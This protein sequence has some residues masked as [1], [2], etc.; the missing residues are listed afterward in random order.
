MTKDTSTDIAKLLKELEEAKQELE[1]AARQMSAARSIECSATNRLNAVQK[2]IDKWY[3]EQKASA[4]WGTDWHSHRNRES[5]P[6]G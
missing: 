2:A 6:A 1:Q 4:S 3:A 5:S